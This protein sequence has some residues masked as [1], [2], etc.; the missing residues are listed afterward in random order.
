MTQASFCIDWE[1]PSVK[2]IARDGKKSLN[3]GDFAIKL[4]MLVEA[5][6]KTGY[7]ATVKRAI[8]KREG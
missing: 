4:D 7:F 8:D 3:K 2:C 1:S 5:Q 6:A